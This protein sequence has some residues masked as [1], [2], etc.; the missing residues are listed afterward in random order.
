MANTLVRF[1]TE[2]YGPVTVEEAWE[3]FMVWPD[4]DSPPFSVHSPHIGLFMSWLFH[5]W[6]PDPHQ[7]TV[8]NEA[9]HDGRP[10]EVFLELHPRVDQW[11]LWSAGIS[12]RAWQLP[13]AFTKS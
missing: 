4:D 11:I 12:R 9:L 8:E 2:T 6:A 13:S 5:A 7:T 3:E 10:T 1:V